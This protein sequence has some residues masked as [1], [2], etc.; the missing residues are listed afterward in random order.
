MSQQFWSVLGNS[1]KLDG[2]AMFGN[3]PQALWSRWH[4]PDEQNRIDLACR[5]LLLKEPDGRTILFETGV[6][7]FFPPE[8]KERYGVTEA[9]HVLLKNLA[10]IGLDQEQIDVVVLS[11]LHFD[12]AGGLLAEFDPSAEKRLFFPRATYVVGEDAFERAVHPHPRDRASFIPEM[13][14]LLEASGRLELVSGDR[15]R[16]LGSRFRMHFS[17][18]HTPG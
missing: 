18:G 10:R 7:A 2:G 9:G 14:G 11:H 12:H 13:P 5:A 8:L 15:S 6:G 4:M 17:E 3:A 1:Q 16:T